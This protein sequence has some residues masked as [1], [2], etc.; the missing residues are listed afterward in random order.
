[1]A[2]GG[3]GAP[4]EPAPV[5]SMG[6]IYYG[7][8]VLAA[9]APHPSF[10]VP[11]M[12]LGADAARFIRSELAGL[13]FD[14][15]FLR[16]TSA[17]QNQV[18]L[19]YTGAEHR[20]EIL[21]G[22]VPPLDAAGLGPFLREIDVLYLNFIAGNELTLPTLRRLRRSFGGPIYADIHSLLLGHGPGGVRVRRPLRTW[23]EWVA[24]FD[25]LQCNVEEAA[26][27]LEA[28]RAR[29]R[30]GPARR[31]WT[32]A[33]PASRALD[34]RGAARLAGLV[35]RLGP[36]LFVLTSGAGSVRAWPAGGGRP[37]RFAPAEVGPRLDP[38]GCGDVL[39][40]AFCAFHFLR[41]MPARRALE[42]AVE[43]A[44][45]KVTRV[46]TDGLAPELRAWFLERH[47]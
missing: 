13:G 47:G 32:R 28:E 26:G 20:R 30:P 15:R 2:R 7:L 23:R 33:K 21:H 22:G 25:V 18:D 5:R 46:G 42:R 35:S 8:H 11:A 6:G 31:G 41:G 19:R 14:T 9:L 37:W 3:G 40:A 29:R 45:W 34:A 12:N 4:P 27:L 16:R 43:I 17:K 44:S 36:R 1:V 24:C 38:T 10:V 39:G